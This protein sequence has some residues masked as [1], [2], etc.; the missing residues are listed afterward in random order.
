[1]DAIGARLVEDGVKRNRTPRAKAA[2]DGL[3]A[4]G[5]I[6]IENHYVWIP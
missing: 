6:R 2:L 4:N 5:L 3:H 1:M